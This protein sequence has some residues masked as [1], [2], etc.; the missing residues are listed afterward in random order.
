[1]NAK[2][3]IP[4]LKFGARVYPENLIGVYSNP[5]ANYF[6]VDSTNGSDNNGG[7]SINQAKATIDAAVGLC[8][9]NKGDV[10]F[11]APAHTETISSA[12][13]LVLDVA[14]VQII[15]LGQGTSRPVLDFTDTAGSVEMDA[16]NVRLSNVIFRANVSAVVVGVNVD[17]H[18]CKI[19]NS[20]FEYYETGD[21]FVTMIDVDAFDGFELTDCELE[22]EDTAGCDEAIR[23]DDA[24]DVK[25]LRNIIYGDFTDGAIIGEGAAGHN[26]LIAQNYVYN[27]DTT[28]GY[29]LD[30]NVAFTGLL[31][32]NTFGTL[33]T[34]APETAL[35]PGSLLSIE[36][37]VCNNVDESG[38]IVP[39]AIS[40]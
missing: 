16:A 26:L 2:D 38:A 27:S 17:A 32:Y 29:V 40:T 3:Y 15:G 30:L 35:D 25:L 39:V 34:T 20:K 10:I 19:D 37:Y 6:Y 22:A 12:T 18:G 8:T 1:M 11:V 4:C 13:S 9:A 28:A 33:Y 7:E 31:A 21:D 24:H 36:N 14:G 23:L 5:F